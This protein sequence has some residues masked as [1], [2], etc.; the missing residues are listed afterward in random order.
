MKPGDLVTLC[1]RGYPR[2]KGQV[3]MLVEQPYAGRW[4]VMIGREHVDCTLHPYVIDEL[5]MEA[6]K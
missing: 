4:I 1:P 2:Y 6:V 5:D 3:G